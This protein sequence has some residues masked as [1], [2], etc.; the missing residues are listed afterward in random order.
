[1]YYELTQLF[2]DRIVLDEIQDSPDTPIQ[3]QAVRLL[4]SY[5][6][7]SENEKESF[8][9]I[10]QGWLDDVNTAGNPVVQLIAAVVFTCQND[11]QNALRTLRNPV[12]LEM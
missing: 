11:Y 4:A 3:L 5:Q 7:A 6:R 9:P 12:N 2:G 10:L 1:M 8:L